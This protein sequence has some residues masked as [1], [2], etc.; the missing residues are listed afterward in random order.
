M[1]QAPLAAVV[2]VYSM[3]L[4]KPA[5][6]R[7][8]LK[9]RR[10]EF[11]WAL[12]A[13]AGVILLGTL[14]GIL[15][16]IVLSL[17]WLA[18]QIADPPV[19]VLGR[20]RGTNVF[21]QL[22]PEHPDDETFPG[23]LILHFSG[24]IFFANAERLSQKI[25]PLVEASGAKVVAFDMSGVPDLEYTALKMLIE[26][27]ERSRELGKSLWLVGLNPEVL[28]VVRRSSLGET[29]GKERMFFNLETAVERYETLKKSESL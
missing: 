27:E 5:E 18:K 8:V 25:K 19:A 28:E 24:R 7:A 29:L 17:I 13:M 9:V 16:A 14:K 23:L 6:F 21:R 3:G 11:L 12:S 1:P 10:M 2:I 26:G 22:S 15:V 20:K 4:I